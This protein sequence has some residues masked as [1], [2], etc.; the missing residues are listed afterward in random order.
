MVVNLVSYIKGG[1]R[2]KIF[3]NRMLRQ[4]FGGIFK[5]MRMGSVLNFILK[6][7]N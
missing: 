1:N 5:G 3:Q 7:D 2:L 6:N 4:I